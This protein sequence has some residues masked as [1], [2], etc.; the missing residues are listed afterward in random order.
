MKRNI[1]KSIKP[2]INIYNP[3][4]LA[5]AAE[6]GGEKTQSTAPRVRSEGNGRKRNKRLRNE[7]A[8]TISCGCWV[9]GFWGTGK[10]C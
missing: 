4:V 2:F 7:L 1:Q 8:L 3:L 6:K 5:M 9:R 10:R